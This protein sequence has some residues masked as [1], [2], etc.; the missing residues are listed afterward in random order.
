MLPASA[1]CVSFK[2]FEEVFYILL[3]A[4]RNFHKC[5]IDGS[6]N[7]HG[8]KG[9]DF[10]FFFSALPQHLKGYRFRLTNLILITHTL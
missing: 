9:D 3:Q 1:I 4:S 8:R 2:S 6:N 10:C 7:S 5:V